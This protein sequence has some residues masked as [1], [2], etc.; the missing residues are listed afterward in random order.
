MS[1]HTTLKGIFAP[2][3]TPVDDALLPDI[4][5]MLEHCRALLDNGCHG[6]VIFGTTGEANSFSSD[7]R[8]HVLASLVEAGL[9]PEKLLVGTGVCSVT[10]TVLLTEH[11]LSLGC[12]GVLMLPPF[13][14]KNVSDEGVFRFYART[15]EQ[16]ANDRLR[17]YLYHIPQFSYTPIR[18]PL[19][20]RLIDAFPNTVVG[21]KDSS[22]DWDN[23]RALLEQFPGF[24]V[25]SG[26]EKFL[27]NTL[28]LNGAGTISAVANVIPEQ[29]RYLY[30]HWES[31]EADAWQAN[32]M[33]TRQ[34][35][36]K[37]GAIPSLKQMVA[38]RHND[39]AWERVRPPLVELSPEAKSAFL[40]ELQHAEVVN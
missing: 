21:I 27:L 25:F 4:P 33:V 6:L 12:A 19:I 17:I 23:L 8:M 15:I 39:P 36:M 11:A 3:L 13:Y 30:E 5:R 37:Y 7:E 20:R 34:L 38:I 22:G 31:P 24:G 26:T 29:L 2:V 35:I 16:I 40:D 9:P 10:E 14:Y 32:L 28:R 1:D 18:L